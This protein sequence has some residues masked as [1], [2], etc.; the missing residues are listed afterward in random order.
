MRREDEVVAESE[1]RERIGGGLKCV[2]VV[3]VSVV[4]YSNR[5]LVNVSERMMC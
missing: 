4:C 5:Y 2:C 3:N 1:E